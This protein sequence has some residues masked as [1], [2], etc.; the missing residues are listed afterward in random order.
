LVSPEVFWPDFVQTMATAN[1][2]AGFVDSAAI[3][4]ADT[5]KTVSAKTIILS[6]CL[7]EN[8]SFGYLSPFP[9][10]FVCRPT[11]HFIRRQRVLINS[12]TASDRSKLLR[13]TYRALGVRQ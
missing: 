5:V 11:H 10:G 4:D 2:F 6:L 8:I 1:G 13:I 7:Y 3:A 9:A 12:S